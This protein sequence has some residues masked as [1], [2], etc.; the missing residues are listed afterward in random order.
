MG[1]GTADLASGETDQSRTMTE[2][3]GRRDMVPCGES[4]RNQGRL[5]EAV[6]AELKEAALPPGTRGSH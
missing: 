5:Q 1:T 6:A 2:N 3:S 4:D